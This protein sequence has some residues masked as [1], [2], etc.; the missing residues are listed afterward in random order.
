M[1]KF[2]EIFDTQIYIISV[3]ETIIF[4]NDNF[5]NDPSLVYRNILT[6]NKR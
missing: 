5:E 6:R 1:K 2:I 4:S 3:N